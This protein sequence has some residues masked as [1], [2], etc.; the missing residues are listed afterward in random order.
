MTKYDESKRYIVIDEEYRDTLEDKVN[1]F[2]AKGYLPLGGVSTHIDGYDQ[3]HFCQALLKSGE[4]TK[5]RP[6]LIY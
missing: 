4:E 6:R 5:S 1:K 3:V 2:L